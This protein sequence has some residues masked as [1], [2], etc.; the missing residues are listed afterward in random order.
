MFGNAVAENKTKIF[1]SLG[2]A[3]MFALLC[4][5]LPRIAA[6]GE[7]PGVEEKGPRAYAYGVVKALGGGME[8][9][10]LRVQPSNV[11]PE[12]VHGNV[13]STPYYGINGG[14]FYQNDLLSIAVVNDVPVNGQTGGYGAGGAN[15]KYARGTLVWD[16]AANAL[17]VQVVR[18]AAEIRVTDRS[19]YWAQGGVSMSLGSDDR[20]AE[21]AAHENAPF[22]DEARLRSAAV[23]DADGNLYL[24]VSAT[25]GTLAE[26]RETV[27]TRIGGGR[28]VDGIFLDGDGSSQLRSR[29]AKLT[30]DGRPVVQ[31]LRLLV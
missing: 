2:I 23:Y 16:G 29:E 26:F 28:L 4:A 7:G 18:D 12:A 31:M 17:S 20:W 30:G 14:F 1:L 9:H 8:L 22:A 25:P 15:V 10:Y 3:V 19:R 5:L 13:V 21:Q 27:K 11:L 6:P 24:I